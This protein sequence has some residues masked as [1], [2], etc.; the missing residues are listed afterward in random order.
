MKRSEI[1]ENMEY[2]FNCPECG[3]TSVSEIDESWSDEIEC[4]S[5]GETIELED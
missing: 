5:C 2:C 3:E 1:W 4:S